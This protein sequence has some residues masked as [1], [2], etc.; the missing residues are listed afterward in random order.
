MGKIPSVLQTEWDWTEAGVEAMG[1]W[2]EYSWGG[3]EVR[4]MPTYAT[5]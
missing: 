3:I 4:F 5:A 1:G 2:G